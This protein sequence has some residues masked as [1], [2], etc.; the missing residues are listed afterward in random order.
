MCTSI[1]VTPANAPY[2]AK[3]YA[4]DCTDK[5]WVRVEPFERKTNS[6][7]NR[8]TVL[9]AYSRDDHRL[10]AIESTESCDAELVCQ[11]LRKLRATNPGKRLLI[12]LD[13]AP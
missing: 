7:R 4:S 8:L 9:R 2:P 5:D 1:C 6:G 12:V 13:S 11:L 10:I 3:R